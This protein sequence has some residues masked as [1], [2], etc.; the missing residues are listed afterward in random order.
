MRLGVG[1]EKD[2]SASTEQLQVSQLV[3]G[4]GEAGVAI[5]EPEDARLIGVCIT[6]HDV[7]GPEV[8]VDQCWLGF[9]VQPVVQVPSDVINYFPT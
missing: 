1:I 8:A 5:N 7:V 2:F 3:F 6:D 4:V 9:V